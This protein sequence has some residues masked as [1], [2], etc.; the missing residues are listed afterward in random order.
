MTTKNN[1][2]QQINNEFKSRDSV[3]ARSM[4]DDDLR[5]FVKR[6]TAVLEARLLSEL[7]EI[8]KTT[9]ET[10]FVDLEFCAKTHACNFKAVN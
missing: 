5:D 3:D 8:R 7:I 2:H 1:P 10:L 9:A 6:T 4:S